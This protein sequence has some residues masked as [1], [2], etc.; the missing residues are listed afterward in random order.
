MPEPRNAAGSWLPD[1]A[2]DS[3]P[4]KGPRIIAPSPPARGLFQEG[5]ENASR[6]RVERRFKEPASPGRRGSRLARPPGGADS[7]T[8]SGQAAGPGGTG[9]PP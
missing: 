7:K 6:A 2:R 9:T 5:E 1:R 3:G 8:V 4:A